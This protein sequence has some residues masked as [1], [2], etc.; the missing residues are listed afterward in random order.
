M[1]VR[2]TVVEAVDAAST[3]A[4]ARI[5]QAAEAAYRSVLGREPAPVG[6]WT[7]STDGVIFRKAGVDT[8]RLGPTPLP[9]PLGHDALSLSGLLDWARLYGTLVLDF[10]AG[11]VA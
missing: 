7:G 2:A 10:C 8:V 5:A 11:N 6:T 9:A 3:P 1:A 4:D